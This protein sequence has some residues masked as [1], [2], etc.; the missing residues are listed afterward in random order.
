MT[1]CY[2]Q[3]WIAFLAGFPVEG[4]PY[5]IASKAF[6][7]WLSGWEDCKFHEEERFVR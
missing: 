7:N 1:D 4:N 5:P 3:G 6:D 2:D